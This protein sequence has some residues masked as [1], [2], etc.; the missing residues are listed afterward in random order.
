LRERYDLESD[1]AAMAI[2]TTASDTIA[3]GKWAPLLGAIALL[4]SIDARAGRLMDFV[5]DYDLNDY[6]LGVAVAVSENPYEGASSSTFAYPYLTSFRHSAFTDDWLLIR[7]ENVGVRFITESGWEFGAIGRIQTLGVGDGQLPGLEERGWAVEMG[8]L[9]G[10]R[11]LP[12]HAQFRSYWEVPDRHSGGTSELELSLPREFS[13][14]FFVPSV[15]FMY[16]SSAYSRYYFGVAESEVVPDRAA[17]EPGAALNY[18]IGFTLGYELTPQWLLKASAGLEVLDPA[19]TASPL[20]DKE[21]LWSG[22]IGLAYNA[23]LFQSKEHGRAKRPGSFIVRVSSFSSRFSTDVRRD[24]SSGAAGDDADFED[25]LGDS[26]SERVLQT[27]IQYR[28]GFFHRLKASYFETDRDLQS[29]LQQDFAFGDELF[30]AGTEVASRIDTRRLS[31]LYGYSLMRDAQKELGVQAGI[32]YART[33][34]DVVAPETGQAESAGVK[35]PLPTMGLFGSVALGNSWELGADIGIFAL[36]VDRY[37]G[38]SGQASLTLDR[39]IGESIAIG[40][41]F[42]YFVTR[43]ESAEDDL[44]GLLRSRNY[45]PKVYLSWLF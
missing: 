43:L 13:R 40:I 12:V 42:D 37:S 34:V 2:P 35:A 5:R 29:T 25:F 44:R 45:G 17:F 19:I 27:E 6:S 31:L 38:Y 22:S 23:D 4:S 14:G 3:L 8:P 33:Y 21:R 36:D 15:T 7:G 9:I 18:R 1:I 39:L 20:V 32:V 10:W 30:L 11:A 16:M 28:I 24:A 41:G 26:S